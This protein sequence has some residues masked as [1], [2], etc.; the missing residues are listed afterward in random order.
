[1]ECYRDDHAGVEIDYML[2]LVRQVG[3]TVVQLGD[4]GLRMGFTDP[5]IVRQLLTLAGAVEGNEIVRTPRLASALLGHLP[6]HF[7]IVF[8]F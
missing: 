8:I 7:T 1:M 6:Q 2:R 3:T 5:L 4:L